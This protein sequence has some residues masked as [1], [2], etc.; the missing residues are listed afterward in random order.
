VPKI[1]NFSRSQNKVNALEKKNDINL[2]LFRYKS[3][4]T[5]VKIVFFC[6]LEDF[7]LL[8]S[9]IIINISYWGIVMLL[10]GNFLWDVLSQKLIV[11]VS[12]AFS[13]SQYF[14]LL[15]LLYI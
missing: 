10:V 6:L 1:P 9:Q 8:Y 4:M 14:F 12:I 3:L 7:F 2:I 11:I 5:I 13:M 15:L